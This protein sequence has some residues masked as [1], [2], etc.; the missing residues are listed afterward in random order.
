MEK[1]EDEDFI[2]LCDDSKENTE[3]R[4]G[5]DD[6]VSMQTVVCI[7]TALLIFS[8]NIAFPEIGEDIF[9]KLKN[10]SDSSDELFPNPIDCIL[11]YCTALK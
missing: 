5:L 4:K 2:E 11:R 10:L 7:L 9:S 8:L 3:K 6:I 1:T